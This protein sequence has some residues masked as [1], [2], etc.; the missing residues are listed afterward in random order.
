MSGAAGPVEHRFV[1]VSGRR[2][3]MRCAGEGPPVLLLHES[4][5]S[6]AA[7]VPMI[8]ALADRFTVIALDTPGYGGSDPLPLHRPQISDYADALK[9]TA[10]ALGLRRIALFG[11]HTG[12][13]I[14]IEFANRWPERVS[15]TVLDG[16][17]LFTPEEMEEL[18]AG[19]LPPFRPEWSG[20]HVA[21][22][23]S[24]IR[25]QFSF[26]PWYRQGSASRIAIGMP[27][28]SVL[29]RIATDF[30]LAG[31]GYRVAYE[32][33]FRYDGGAAAALTRVPTHYVASESDVLL[34]T[35]TGCPRSRQARGRCCSSPTCW[36]PPRDS[37][38]SPSIWRGRAGSSSS[39]RRATVFR[40]PPRP[41]RATAASTSWRARWLHSGSAGSMSPASR[42]APAAPR[43][44]WRGQA[45]AA[46]ASCWSTRRPTRLPWPPASRR[47][48]SC[49][50]GA[51]STCLPPGSPRATPC[52]TGPGLS[53]RPRRG[54]RS[55]SGST[56]R[57]CTG[58]SSIRSSPARPS[59]RPACSLRP[60]VT[61]PARALGGQR[62]GR[63]RR[64]HARR[65][66]AGYARAHASAPVAR[67]RQGPRGYAGAILAPTEA[68]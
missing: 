14:A 40:P 53:P 61:G 49:P 28:P 31:D 65:G 60:A 46:A 58:A 32:A 8:E 68:G 56:W 66:G 15:G 36:A 26:F 35:S 38:P 23:W 55:R 25:D 64:G 3:M 21:W 12:A 44:L 17:P 29:N 54:C 57:C 34:A 30:L 63:D 43:S 9:E 67:A 13:S 1:A 48:R 7:F 51:A 18:V 22:L 4:P 37:A 16:C 33:A 39:I 62:R 5:R 10:D 19:Y 45:P 2:V 41:E 42:R 59:P 52:S 11:R 24:R 47:T 27:R 50:R 6:S 20:S